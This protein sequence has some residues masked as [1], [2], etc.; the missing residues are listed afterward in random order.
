V[1]IDEVPVVEEQPFSEEEPEA[2]PAEPPALDLGTAEGELVDYGSDVP[3]ST[4]V[5]EVE[6]DEEIEREQTAQDVPDEAEAD[7]QVPAAEAG[8]AEEPEESA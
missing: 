8:E 4:P 3:P 6:A 7:L 5:H 1:Q 2:G